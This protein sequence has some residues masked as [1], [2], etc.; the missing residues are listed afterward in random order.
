MRVE[1]FGVVN[2]SS[3][4]FFENSEAIHT[5]LNNYFGNMLIH[6]LSVLKSLSEGWFI[7]VLT[8]ATKNKASE[9]IN[10]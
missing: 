10:R 6:L 7:V 8:Y 2:S 5:D 4:S 3:D 9:W 1:F